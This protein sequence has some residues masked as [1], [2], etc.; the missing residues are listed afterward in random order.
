MSISSS[1]SANR[2]YQQRKY[3]RDKNESQGPACD[4]A[5]AREKKQLSDADRKQVQLLLVTCT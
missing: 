4:R 5:K 1:A 3:A 2:K